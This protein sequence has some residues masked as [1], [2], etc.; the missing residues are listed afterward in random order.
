MFRGGGRFFRTRCSTTYTTYTNKKGA[1][2]MPHIDD[3]ENVVS[4]E[5]TC[6]ELIMFVSKYA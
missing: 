1:I 6:N 5:G 4:S 2:F 3:V